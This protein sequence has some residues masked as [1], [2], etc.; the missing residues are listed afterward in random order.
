MDIAALVIF[1]LGGLIGIYMLT[2]LLKGLHIPKGLSLIHGSLMAIGF[3]LLVVYNLTT[4][5]D[6]KHWQS[7]SIFAVAII[8]GVASL[9]RDLTHKRKNTL[10]TLVHGVVGFS[11][12][13]VLYLHV[14]GVI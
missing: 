6:H 8:L 13:V 7:V 2:F 10:F 1:T 4:S 3:V 5:N 11:G 12:I 9:W 14:L